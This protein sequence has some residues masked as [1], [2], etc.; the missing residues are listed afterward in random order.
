M[1]FNT[2][3]TALSIANGHN[4]LIWQNNRLND[5]ADWY[6]NGKKNKAISSY[7]GGN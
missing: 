2:N 7:L 1:L 5:K 4:T 6:L 3:D